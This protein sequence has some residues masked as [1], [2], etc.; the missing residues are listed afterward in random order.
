MAI[1]VTKQTQ[2]SYKFLSEVTLNSHQVN[3]TIVSASVRLLLLLVFICFV[4][5]LESRA[6]ELVDKRATV[7]YTPT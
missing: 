1:K 4:L 5:S 2:L 3:R 6:L 7:S